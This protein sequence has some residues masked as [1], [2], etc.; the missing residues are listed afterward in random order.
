MAKRS[1]DFC[2]VPKPNSD[3]IAIPSE[4]NL[5]LGPDQ[6][7]GGPDFSASPGEKHWNQWQRR[8]SYSVAGT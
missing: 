5:F 4:Q 7:D 6:R 1:E 2:R 8:D 3:L